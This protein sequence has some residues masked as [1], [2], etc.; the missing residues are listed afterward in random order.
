[1]STSGWRAYLDPSVLR[2]LPL[3]FCAALPWVLIYGT[4][5]YRL[6]EGGTALSTIGM[7]SWIALVYPGKWIWSPLLDHLDLPWLSARLGR[8]RAWLVAAQ[9]SAAL[10]LAWM[11]GC[12]PTHDLNRLMAAT[13]LTALA[14]ATQDVALD[15]YRIE[16]TDLSRQ[17]ASAA[18]YQSGYRLGMIWAG[19]GA[20]WLAAVAD[21]VPAQG[22]RVAYDCMALSL[23]IGPLTVLLGTRAM[24]VAEAPDNPDPRFV[25]RAWQSALS[26]LLDFARRYRWHALLLLAFI[27]SFRFASIFMGIMS[28]PFY[29]DLGFTKQQVAAVSKIYGVAMALIGGFAGG[30]LVLRWGLRR[31][32]WIAPVVSSLAILPYAALAQHG[33]S[34]AFLT[35]VISLDNF[36]EG[37]A[38]TVFIAYLSSLTDR[39]HTASQYAILS[40]ATVLLPKLAGG[41]SGWLVESIGY[42]A[43]FCLSAATGAIALVLLA[44]VQRYVPD[45]FSNR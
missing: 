32:L 17:A 19:A 43:F 33:P 15:A 9:A 24:P 25:R 27:S 40:S 2:M 37:V 4:L 12:D 39:K 20:L 8:R 13:V 1:L 21:P 31:M 14:G 42:S 6:R 23:L 16:S 34:V 5:S 22:W 41:F 7:M 29:H 28:N 44:L 3:G 26:P 45:D 10:G 18:V 35:L 11:A 38:G 30:A 36:A